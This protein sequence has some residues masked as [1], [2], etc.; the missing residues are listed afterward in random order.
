M[1]G[2]KMMLIMMMMIMWGRNLHHD[3]H[4]GLQSWWLIL[5]RRW[6][7]VEGIE[8]MGVGPFLLSFTF[9]WISCNNQ[10][11]MLEAST[12]WQASRTHVGRPCV[13][14]GTHGEQTQEVIWN[15]EEILWIRVRKRLLT[16]FFVKVK[17]ILIVVDLKLCAKSYIFV[18]ILQKYV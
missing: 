3:H 9:M 16:H 14:D 8:E 7:N 4:H 6:S 17:T 13:R 1:M 2:R 11:S 18:P 15:F 5:I 10:Y 12:R